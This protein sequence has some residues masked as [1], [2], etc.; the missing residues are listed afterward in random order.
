MKKHEKS[1]TLYHIEKTNGDCFLLSAR[2]HDYCL[3]MEGQD[4]T[5]LSESMFNTSEYE[6]F[7]YFDRINTQKLQAALKSDD[8]L[9]S[10]K[11]FFNEENKNQKFEQFCVSNQIK[12]HYG[13]M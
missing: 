4:F 10:L 6:Y 2:I 12:Y 7:Y 3:L 9:E 5:K 1:I 11:G 13:T 8:L